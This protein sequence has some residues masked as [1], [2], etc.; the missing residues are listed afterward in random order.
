M[1]QVS[2]YPIS[3]SV[4]EQIFNLLLKIFSDSCTKTEANN[5]LEDLLTPTERIMLAKR[6][7]IA[8]LLSKKYQY[9]DIS[10]IL[11]VS[12]G[13]IAMINLSLKFTGKGYKY[14]ID[15]VL[16]E[17]KLQEIWENIE[18]TILN[19]MSSGKGSHTWRYLRNELSNK[20]KKRV[21]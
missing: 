11:R 5:L 10:K 4:Y 2:K 18:K 7:A 8:L 17:E 20:K 13:T 16:R 12:K 15:K 9:Q 21:L 1:A 3:Q 14:F 6:L 19:T